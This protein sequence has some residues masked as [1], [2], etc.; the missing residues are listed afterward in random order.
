MCSQPCERRPTQHINY[1][2]RL[3]DLCFN[4]ARLKRL[5]ISAVICHNTW[6]NPWKITGKLTS[7]H[8]LKLWTIEPSTGY[9]HIQPAFLKKHI[10]RNTCHVCASVQC[11]GRTFPWCCHPDGGDCSLATNK[12]HWWC[13]RA[14][15]QSKA[16][17]WTICLQHATAIPYVVHASCYVKGAN[18]LWTVVM[19]VGNFFYPLKY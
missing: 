13:T 19:T 8:T 14:T 5:G 11:A 18:G 3:P 15:D 4:L 16:H 9:W 7:I 6:H 17:A 2:W 1:F 10:T 12:A